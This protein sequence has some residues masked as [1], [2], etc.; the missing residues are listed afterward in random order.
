[1]RFIM[2]GALV[3]ALSPL[4]LF[5]QVSPSATNPVSDAV[6]QLLSRDSKNLVASA[7][8]MPPDKYAYHPTPAQI[9][10]G[11]L[12]MHIAQSNVSLCSAISGT[13]PANLGTLA[14]TDPKAALVTAIRQSFDY[15][16]QAL[17]K[18]TDAQ[19]GDEVTLFGTRKGTR[20]SAMITIATDWADHYSSAAMYLRL[21]G[22]L[23][24]TA[25]PGK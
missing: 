8:L 5:A 13:P 17:A 16:T 14:E 6:R 24:P 12:I 2:V 4:A 7:E 11:H 1:M 20:A 23:P 19:L 9:T 25:A 21:N 3:G 15:C 18:V 10:F 22:L